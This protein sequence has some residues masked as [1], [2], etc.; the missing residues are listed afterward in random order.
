MQ[1]RKEKFLE[2]IVKKDYKNKLEEVLEHKNFSEQTKSLLL[3]MLYKIENAYSDYSKVKQNVESKDEYIENIISIIKNKCNN[4]EVISPRSQKSAELGRRVFVIDDQTKS[5]K[6]YPVERKLLYAISKIAKK[7][8]IIDKEKYGMIAKPLSDLINIG[9]NINTV[10]PLRDFNGYSWTTLNREIESIEY[11]LIYQNLR[12]LLGY[13]LLKDW[14][15]NEDDNIDYMTFFER[16][17]K[18]IYGESYKKIIKELV[19]RLAML[20]EMKFYKREKTENSEEEIVNLM[21]ELQKT[22]LKCFEIKIEQARTKLDVTKLLYEFRYFYLLPFDRKKSICEVE[23]LKI[24]IERTIRVLIDRMKLEGIIGEFSKRKD[25]E[26]KIIKSILTLKTIRLEDIYVMAS[27]DK[28]RNLIYLTIFDESE[29]EQKIE[30]G[31]LE[32]IQKKDLGIKLNKKVR[33]FY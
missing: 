19:I 29:F 11:N 27:K 1:R 22:F 24:Q 16:T 13:K 5:I 33:V 30:L 6:C 17:I 21:I 9:N 2:K 4:I 23:E 14:S 20:L 8:L 12:I 7:D 15:E 31:T 3:S 25:L 18:D 10:E 26:T 28:E 32:E